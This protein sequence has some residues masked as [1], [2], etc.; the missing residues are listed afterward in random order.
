MMTFVVL[1]ASFALA[2]LLASIIMT[3]LIYTLMCNSEVMAWLVHKYMKAMEKS[4]EDFEKKF[5]DLGA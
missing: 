5:E 4:M 2:I 3:V 1:T